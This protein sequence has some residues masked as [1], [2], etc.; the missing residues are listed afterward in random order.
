MK[1]S[2]STFGTNFDSNIITVLKIWATKLEA[3]TMFINDD[4]TVSL[5]CK[6]GCICENY[7]PT[8]KELYDSFR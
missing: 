7:A 4:N 6:D 3:D 8:I 2:Y 1:I 5:Y